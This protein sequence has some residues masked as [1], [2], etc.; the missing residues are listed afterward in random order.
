MER[1]VH[2]LKQAPGVSI[3]LAISLI[4]MWIVPVMPSRT[5]VAFG[6]VFRC[7]FE[8]KGDHVS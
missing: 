6:P 5:L 3:Y 1:H 2:F 7:G 4:H 8:T